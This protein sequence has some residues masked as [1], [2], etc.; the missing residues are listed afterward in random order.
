L[1]IRP[2]THCQNPLA[3]RE[4]FGGTILSAIFQKETEKWAPLTLSHVSKAITIVHDFIIRLLTS[5]CPEEQVRNKLWDDF[6]LDHL[7]RL[8]QRAMAHAHF[9][10]DIEIGEEPITFNHYFNSTLQQ[11]RN[12]RV[13]G[14]LEDAKVYSHNHEEDIVLVSEI[15]ASV[16][17]KSNDEQVC[18]DILD[19]LVSYY[20]VSRKRFVDVVCQQVIFH[21]LLRSKD[22]PPNLF[23]PELVMGLSSEQLDAIAGEDED[24]KQGR[25]Q[26]EREIANLEAA[27][28]VLR[29]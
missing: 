16:T 13:I 18:D 10:L 3:N 15:E 1:R 19:A 22:G 11:K 14:P 26:L 9:L 5:L 2:S 27:L 12:Q 28:K 21:L 23:G 6:L 24:S 4:Q 7:I 25:Q 8:Y 29:G 20:K 17:N